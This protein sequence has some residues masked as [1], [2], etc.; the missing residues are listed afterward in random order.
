MS[1]SQYVCRSTQAGY[2]FQERG[3]SGLVLTS[4]K[5][6]QWVVYGFIHPVAI[7]PRSRQTI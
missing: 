3:V 2:D 6:F 7:T 1:Q 4:R 5:V